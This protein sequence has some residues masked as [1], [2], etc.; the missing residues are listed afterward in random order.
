MF[1]V[2]QGEEKAKKILKRVHVQALNLTTQE[3]LLHTATSSWLFLIPPL[4]FYF[5]SLRRLA[6][7]VAAV[8]LCSVAT[9]LRQAAFGQGYFWLPP[10]LNPAVILQWIIHASSLLSFPQPLPDFIPPLTLAFSLSLSPP[11]TS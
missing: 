4:T 7:G 6:A 10:C 11:P 2:E 8:V 1:S 9:T 3:V 5:L